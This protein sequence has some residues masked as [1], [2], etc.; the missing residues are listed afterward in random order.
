MTK[1]L[2]VT[3]FQ[4]WNRLDNQAEHVA[5]GRSLMLRKMFGKKVMGT[6]LLSISFFKC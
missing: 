2:F 5:I 6:V 1:K 3:S 4:V